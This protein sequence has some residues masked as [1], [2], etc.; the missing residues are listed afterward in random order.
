MALL[1]SVTSC[2]D[3]GIDIPNTPL[4]G[5]INGQDWTY[6]FTSSA[7]YS[8]SPTKYTFFLFSEEELNNDPCAAVS[9]TKPHLRVILPLQI[10]SYPLGPQQG[11]ENLRFVYGNGGE[12]SATSGSVEILAFDFRRMAGYIQAIGDDNNTVEGRF[13]AELCL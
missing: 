7:L 5:K 13:T 3:D 11:V 9:S 1:V 12:F 6:S 4:S 8:G 2:L 10:G